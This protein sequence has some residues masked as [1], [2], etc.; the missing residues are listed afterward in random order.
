MTETANEVTRTPIDPN[1]LAPVATDPSTRLSILECPS[2]GGKHSSIAITEFAKPYGIFTH[3]FQCP[4]THDPGMISIHEYRG[5]AEEVDRL[6]CQY[7][8][9]AQESG[10]W[11]AVY[12]RAVDGKLHMDVINHHLPHAD[13]ENAATLLRRD[14]LRQLGQ[15]DE[16]P[17]AADVSQLKPTYSLFGDGAEPL[18]QQQ[19]GK[20]APVET[21][22]NSPV[23]A[24]TD[25]HDSPAA[26]PST[27]AHD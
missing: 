20:D 9:T 15:G 18:Q 21:N 22:P 16:A 27:A 24:E 3:H 8:L 19:P 6:I 12:F 23:T 10:R 25:T 17:K 4:T 26:S 5:T 7:A 2:C 13:W 11:M 1:A 14:L